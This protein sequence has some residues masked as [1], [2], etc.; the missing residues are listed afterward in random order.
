MDNGLG[1]TDNSQKFNFKK[2]ISLYVKQWKWFLLSVIIFVSIVYIHLRYTI[3][4]YLASSKIMLLSE[5]DEGASDIFKDLAISNESES[6]SVEDEIL[7]FKSRIVLKSVVEK[8]GLNIQ[9]FTK[10]VVL[11]TEM[12]KNPPIDVHV[13]IVDSLSNSIRSNFFIDVI[14]NDKFKYR[15]SEEGVTTEALFGES[16]ETYFGSVVISPVSDKKMNSWIGKTIRVKISNVVDVVENLRNRVDVYSSKNSS[17]IITISLQNRVVQKA[18][19]IINTLIIEYD[20][21]TSEANNRKSEGTAKLIDERINRIFLDLEGV[22]ESIARFKISNKVTDVGSQ[23]SQLMGQSFQNEQETDNIRTQ[24]KLLNFTKEQ[25]ASTS[26][27]YQSI[28]TNLGDP[29]ISALSNQYNELIAQRENKLRSA[30]A[31]NSVVLQLSQTIANVK[32]N[33]SQNINATIRTLNIQLSSLQNQYQ[34]VSTKISSVPGQEN[35]LKSIERSQGIKEAIYLYLLEK[36]E[37]A[38]ISQTVTSSNVKVIDPAYSYG[39][40]SP[41]GKKLYIGVFFL[42]LVIPFGFI[43]VK[44]LLDTKI[45]NKE[46]LQKEIKNITILGEIP[47][48]QGKKAGTLIEKNDR[49]ILSES[50]RIIRTNFDFVRRGRSNEGEAYD[51]V[52]YV[53]STINGEGKSFFS[54]NMAVTL[55]NSNKRVLLIGADIRNPQTHT[56]LKDQKNNQISKIGLTE[57]LVDKSIIVGEAIN[58]YDINDNKIDIMFSGKVPPNPA[59]LLMNDR[60]KLLFDNVSEQYDYVIVD[61][62]PS[63]LVTDTLLISQYA[64]HTIYLTRAGYTEKEILNFAKE[65]HENNKLNGM[66]LVVNDVK[67]SNFGYGAKYGY[68][69][70]SEKKGWFKRKA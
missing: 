21:Y 66:M 64:G 43:Y 20:K 4:E 24:L 57:F 62:A 70:A 44:D 47:E 37:E 46:D 59:E 22:D 56:I 9:Y 51:N 10:G 53:T 63:M 15:L 3:P 61:T 6:A 39:Q 29:S 54:M 49:S 13:I 50:F 17:K 65:L 42:A 28:P 25:L 27:A 7:V 8:L 60:M 2:T 58:T 69:G 33:L 67:Q 23:G 68:Y 48:V 38:I 14:S 55:A 19:D 41:N 45:H 36:K 32:S 12:Y 11:E 5:N 31:K 30:G 1:S 26:N 16:I 40:V 52:I 18:K 35:K 34:S